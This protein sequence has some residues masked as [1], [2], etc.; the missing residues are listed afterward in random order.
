[1]TYNG[2]DIVYIPRFERWLTYSPKEL[3]TIFTPRE[4]E[5][6]TKRTPK[7]AQFLASRFAVKEAFYK[8]VSATCAT[9]TAIQ[10]FG[11]RS[12]ARFIEIAPDTRWQSPLLFFDAEGFMQA[13]GI[14]LPTLQATVSLAHDG[15]YAIAQVCVF[16]K[17][18]A[19]TQNLQACY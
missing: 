9:N 18:Q 13:T 16:M 19:Q 12:I 14:E 5:E 15:E 3:L 8:A 1:M 11:F 10:P 4:L 6:L 2:I 7:Q 17:P